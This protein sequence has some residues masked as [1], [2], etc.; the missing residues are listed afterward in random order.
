MF[1]GGL[2]DRYYFGARF[3]EAEQFGWDEVVV[4][5]AIG[6]WDEA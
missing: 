2:S 3:C 5:Y 1:S 4:E 6:F